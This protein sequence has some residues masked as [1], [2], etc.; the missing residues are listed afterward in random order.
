M[1]PFLLIAVFLFVFLYGFG[2][3]NTEKNGLPAIKEK[4]ITLG[5][6]TDKAMVNSSIKKLI[7]IDARADT[8]TL[9]FWPSDD[10][11][12]SLSVANL[13]G[14]IN[15][16]LNE[17]LQIEKSAPADG[18]TIVAVIRKLWLSEK[19]QIDPESDGSNNFNPKRQGGVIATF[20]FY[21]SNGKGYTPLYRFD[22]VYRGMKSIRFEAQEFLDNLLIMSV[23]PLIATGNNFTPADKVMALDEIGNYSRQQY[24]LPI[25]KAGIYKK[26]VY[27]TFDEF[28]INNP[29]IV[30]NNIVSNKLTKT[31]F[32][33]DEKGEY[34][35]RDVWG[36]S[37]GSHVFIK[38]GDNYF[39]LIKRQN[40]F[41]TF[42]ARSL[43]AMHTIKLGNILMLGVL[44]GTVGRQNK[45]VSYDLVLRLYELDLDTG[46]LY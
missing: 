31:I 46:E 11:Y 8:A 12:Y 18:N 14:E 16:F 3:K 24:D 21:Y 39:E 44:F 41:I 40:T 28:K 43:V 13:T 25:I 19:L 20:E 4:S 22:T 9:G 34:P 15:T 17:Y 35:V 2:Q 27:N 32:S 23:Q 26:G 5:I 1:K 29:S 33:K 37:D 10:K 42:A 45:K 38:S 30:F 36:Y 6:P 7:V